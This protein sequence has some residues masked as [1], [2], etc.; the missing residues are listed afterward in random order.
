LRAAV[1][2]RHAID[3]IGAR[4]AIGGNALVHETKGLARVSEFLRA[5]AG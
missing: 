3:L 4:G 5:K 1:G 2:E